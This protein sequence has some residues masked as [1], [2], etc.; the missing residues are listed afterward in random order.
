MQDSKRELPMHLAENAPS[1]CFVYRNVKL[2]NNRSVVISYARGQD[3]E[4]IRQK[5]IS[6][7][8]KLNKALGPVPHY[9]PE[10]RMTSRNTSGIV[11]VNPKRNLAK[12]NGLYYYFWNAKWKGCPKSGGVPWPCIKH[13][14]DG[15]YVLAALTVKLRTVNR[16]RVIEECEKIKGTKEY[17]EILKLRPQI[18]IEELWPDNS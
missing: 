10:G 15:A 16:D 7:A 6:Y 2:N 13:T 12:R 18:P 14:D 17:R 3:Y 1:K 9:S 11:R 8:N 4:D 5:A